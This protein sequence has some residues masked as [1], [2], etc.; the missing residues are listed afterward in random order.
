MDPMNQSVL[1][2]QSRVEKLGDASNFAHVLTI[3]FDNRWLIAGIALITALL[4]MV[5]V[6]SAQSPPQASISIQLTESFNPA[7]NSPDRFLI[8]RSACAN[9]NDGDCAA[10]RFGAYRMQWSLAGKGDRLLQAIHVAESAPYGGTVS[11]KRL[12]DFQYLA[13]ASAIL[14]GDWIFQET[15][16]EV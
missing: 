14:R 13:A 9:Q 8:Q 3:L 12:V 1:R 5:C 15:H 2:S 7:G 16:H 6:L 4:A 11:R 10:E